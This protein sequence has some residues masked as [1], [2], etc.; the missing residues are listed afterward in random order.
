MWVIGC[1]LKKAI[2]Q[3]LQRNIN[4]LKFNLDLQGFENLEGLIIII[5]WYKS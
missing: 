4:F 5:A 3:L 1:G 2:I